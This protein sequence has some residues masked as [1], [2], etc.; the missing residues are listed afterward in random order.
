MLEIINRLNVLIKRVEES[1]FEFKDKI[2]YLCK[3][4]LDCLNLSQEKTLDISMEY[5]VKIF[6]DNPLTHAICFQGLEPLDSWDE[7]KDFITLFRSQS[8]APIV[9]YTGYNK[10]EIEDKIEWLKEQ[11]P[12]IIKYGRFVLNQ[13]PHYDAVLGVNLASDNQYAE[14][15]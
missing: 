15:L 9:I 2:E 13:Q 14:E 12:M 10:E 7:L 1:E 11:K 8:T 5:I 4:N 3:F 6:N